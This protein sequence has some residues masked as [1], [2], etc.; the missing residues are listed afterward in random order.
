VAKVA[1]SHTTRSRAPG[2]RTFIDTNILCYCDDPSD[3]AKQAIALNLVLDHLSHASGVVSVQVLQEY[4]VNATRK[5]KLDAGMVRRKVEAYTRFEV[6]EPATAD[7]FAAID[8]HRLHQ[9]SYWDALIL[10]CA[11]KSGCK[12]VLTEDMQHGQ[13]ID[14]VRIMNP[15]R[16]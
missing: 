14:G 9:L 1:S 3:K 5:L 7:I 2:A 10:Q 6:V 16:K 13:M 11:K 4:F 8:L 12:T 15:F